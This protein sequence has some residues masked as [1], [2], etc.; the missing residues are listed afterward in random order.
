MADESDVLLQLYA[1]E[2]TQ[3]RQM[4]DQRAA[5][6]NIII[7]VVGA[8]L[9]LVTSRGIGSFQRLPCRSQ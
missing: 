8:G 4:E 9:A 2:R 5:L 3:A 6:T 1:E 7:L